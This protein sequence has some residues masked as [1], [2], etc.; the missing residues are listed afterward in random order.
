[1]E[2]TGHLVEWKLSLPFSRLFIMGS[3]FGRLHLLLSW[4]LCPIRIDLAWDTSQYT[5]RQE[6][7]QVL[8]VIMSYSHLGAWDRKEELNVWRA[9][10]W[11]C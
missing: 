1:M 9:P 10:P 11:W 2:W 4:H 6:P 8:L 5:S 7:T 3:V